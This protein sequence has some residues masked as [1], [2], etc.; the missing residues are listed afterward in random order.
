MF[1]STPE[2]SSDSHLRKAFPLELDLR[3]L[4]L[5]GAHLGQMGSGKTLNISSR[6]VQFTAD[7]SLGVGAPVRLSIAWPALLNGNCPLQLVVCGC[8]VRSEQKFT[9]LLTIEQHEFRT[10][11]ESRASEELR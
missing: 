10:R 8:I 9:H 5:Y 6:Q 4:M 7:R 3:Y 11:S 1:S 2:V